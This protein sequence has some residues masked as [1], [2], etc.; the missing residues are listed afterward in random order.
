MSFSD[1]DPLNH[2]DLR[3]DG[4]KCWWECESCG[5]DGLRSHQRQ[6]PTFRGWD[7]YGAIGDVLVSW[8]NHLKRSHPHVLNWG[9]STVLLTYKGA[10]PAER[11][12]RMVLYLRDMAQKEEVRRIAE[13]WLKDGHFDLTPDGVL[14]PIDNTGHD[15]IKA[16]REGERD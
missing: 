5:G 6:D 7:L 2:L 9:K 10:P 14:A 16:F 8:Q 1:H 12:R 11:E 15:I 13:R 3:V 4:A